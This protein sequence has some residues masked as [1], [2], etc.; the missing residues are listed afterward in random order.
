M[1]NKKHFDKEILSAWVDGHETLSDGDSLEYDSDSMAVWS[2]YHVIGQ[3]MRDEAQHLDLDISANVSAAIADEPAHKLGSQTKD[4]QSNRENVIPFPNRMWK[5]AG[6][7]AIAASV[8]IV[9]LFSVSNTQPNVVGDSS[10]AFANINAGVNADVNSAETMPSSS[11]VLANNGTVSNGTVSNGT[12]SNGTVSNEAV[13]DASRQEL[14]TMHEMF[15]KHESLARL[16]GTG[17]LPT[18]QVVS[19]QKVIPINIPMRA[20]EE[21]KESNGQGMSSEKIRKQ[22]E[23]Q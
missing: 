21:A 11:V 6:G 20:N 14:Q 23:S 1:G 3:V 10:T 7:F 5:Q 17:G 19:N 18:V 12:V 2:R 4:S 15:L 16:T 22:D 13:S 8:A 9:A